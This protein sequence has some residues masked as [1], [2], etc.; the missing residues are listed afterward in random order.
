MI[1]LPWGST[2][3]HVPLPETWRVLGTF[4]PPEAAAADDPAAECAAALAEPYGAE[5]LATRDLRGKRVLLV[6]DDVSRPTPVHCFFRPVRDALLS[7]GV[8]MHDIEVLF[9][10][11]VH[12]PMTQAEA[13]AKLGAENA[14]AHRW[15]NHD[16][17]DPNQLVSLG[18][19]ERGTPLWFN[20]LLTQ[21]DLIVPL[22]AIEPHTLLGFSGGCK[23]LLPGCAGAETIGRNHMQ[24]LDQ[25]DFNYVGVMPDESPMRLDLEE[26]VGRLG[27]ELFIVNAALT[28]DAR[29]IRFFC[30]SPIEAQRAGSEYVREHAEVVVPEEADVVITNSAPFDADLRQS[31][32]CM[33]NTFFS[34]RPGG[35]VLGFLRC[36]EGRGDVPVPPKSLPY[37]VFRTLMRLIG[38]RRIM[39]FVKVFKKGDPI[40]QQFLAH[41]GLQTLRRNHLFIYS[42]TLDADCGKQIGLFRQYGDVE[43]MMNDAVAQV[44]RHATVAIFPKGG[45]TFT[46]GPVAAEALV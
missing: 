24:G 45:C 21:F 44:G 29:V 6:S 26:G 13:E 19:T 1:E 33:G 38:K 31:M 39:S 10:L 43:Q 35:L 5:P 25:G 17:F 8:A 30:G 12:R 15:H 14:A 7:A 46:R 3:L 23:M 11:G 28:S 36:N 20:R 27:R 16:A 32:K 42:E 34:T 2:T 40:E 22:G 4:L 41:F 9:A 18:T 37:S